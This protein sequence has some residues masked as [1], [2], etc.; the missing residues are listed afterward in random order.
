MNSD[1]A[2]S[3]VLPAKK[4]TLQRYLLQDRFERGRL[5]AQHRYSTRLAAMLQNKLH[6]V[7]RFTVRDFIGDFYSVPPIHMTHLHCSLEFYPSSAI[8]VC[9]GIDVSDWSGWEKNRGM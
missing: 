4:Q 9:S 2:R 3:P 6:V 5:N 7:A 1:V 8:E